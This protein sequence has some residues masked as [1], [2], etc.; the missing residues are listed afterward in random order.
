MFATLLGGN[1][2]HNETVLVHV[3]AIADDEE[4]VTAGQAD[5]RP[6]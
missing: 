4:F 2:N 5:A 3:D 1:L 6:R